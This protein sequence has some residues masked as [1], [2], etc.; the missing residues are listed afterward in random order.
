MTAPFRLDGRTALVTGAGRGIGRS[1]ALA[2]AAAGADLVLVSRTQADLEEVAAIASAHGGRAIPFPADLSSMEGARALIDRLDGLPAVD[3]L[4]N[5]AGRN[6]PQ[7]ALDTTE[8][9]WDAMHT[10]NLK[11]PFFLAQAV[12]RGMI[13]R[14]KGGRIVFI[15][16]QMGSVGWLKR[17][18]Y[19]SSKGGVVQLT[20]VL[21][22]EWAPHGVRVNCVAPTFIDTPG[23][24][25]MMTTDPET[26]AAVLERIPIG[27]L[28]S[29]EEVAHAVLYLASQ[30]A[31]LVTGHTLL[32]DGGW[33]A[34]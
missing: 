2:L 9:A 32:V 24:R 3:I 8:E 22:L 30:E 14:G 1:I 7:L 29:P 4:V 11:V 31:D 34:Q 28:G 10:L 5:N 25:A 12:G 21:A 26:G 18:A 16:S 6:I 19:C 33:T 15:G 17:A 13:E 27:R 23:V 20:K